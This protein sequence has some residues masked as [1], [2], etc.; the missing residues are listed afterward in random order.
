MSSLY[1]GGRSLL[2]VLDFSNDD[3]LEIFSLASKYLDSHYHEHLKNKVVVSVFFENSTRTYMS[4]AVAARRLS[5]E[6]ITF[7][8]AS[9]SIQ[10]GETI[11]D[12][13][14]TLNTLNPDC[15]VIRHNSSGAVS[16][17]AQHTKCSVINAGDGLNEHPTQALTDAFVILQ[18]YGTIHDLNVTICGDIKYSR[19]AHSNIKLLTSLGANVNLVAPPWLMDKEL[20]K[21]KNI[22]VYYNIQDAIKDADVIMGIRPQCERHKLHK[23]DTKEHFHLYGISQK[24]LSYCRKKNITIMHPGPVNRGVDI[25]NKILNQH[26]EIN[27]QVKCGVA[28]RQAILQFLLS[29]K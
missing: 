7:P 17:L 24:N 1:S 8:I 19:V 16:L 20:E 28:I 22:C 25:C 13:M 4:F 29:K 6:V 12:T 14:T 3:L 15:I 23:I 2:S 26:T 9:S 27:T 11:M 10:K 18:N 5:A 21:N